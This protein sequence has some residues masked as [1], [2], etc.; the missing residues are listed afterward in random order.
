MGGPRPMGCRATDVSSRSW[1][2][3]RCTEVPRC[4]SRYCTREGRSIAP[5]CL[6]KRCNGGLPVLGGEYHSFHR[7]CYDKE[8]CHRDNGTERR[9]NG[10][11]IWPRSNGRRRR[12]EQAEAEL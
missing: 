10:R 6:Y 12:L 5:N 1:E 9:K 3:Q 8:L 2:R 11:N 4:V 7:A